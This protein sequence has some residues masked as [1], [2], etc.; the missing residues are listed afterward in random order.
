MYGLLLTVLL[1]FIL[2]AKIHMSVCIH[3]TNCPYF[4]MQCQRRKTNLQNMG[5]FTYIGFYICC[6]PELIA[7]VVSPTVFNSF[8]NNRVT[9]LLINPDCIQD[10]END[11]GTTETH[12]C[13]T[14]AGCVIKVVVLRAQVH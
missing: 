2:Y 11:V 8:N 5:S 13:K 7:C 9:T 4:N 10:S 3:T 14:Y 6:F 1:F 12:D